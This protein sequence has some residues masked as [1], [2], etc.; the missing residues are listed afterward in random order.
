MS[1]THYTHASPDQI[2]QATLLRLAGYTLPAI[3]EK[4]GLSGSTLYRH[5]SKNGIKKG[6][7]KQEAIDAAHKE[8]LGT[9]N[10]TRQLRT[11]L[12]ALIQSDIALT[13][14]LRDRAMLVLS[15]LDP[16]SLGEAALAAR[17]LAATATALK[18]TSDTV[19]HHLDRQAVKQGE[20][21]SL[22]IST[23]FDPELLRSLG[24]H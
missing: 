5:F 1:G 20:P 17:A 14:Q 12:A 22:D 13:H 2:E 4:V 7:I 18:V 3:A 15:Q 23:I 10:G 24:V 16:G 11:E 19:A 6:A 8:L 21:A 9:I